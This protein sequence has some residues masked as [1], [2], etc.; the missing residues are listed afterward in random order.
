MN[1][2]SFNAAQ[3]IVE[4]TVKEICKDLRIADNVI[5]EN[6]GDYAQVAR[7][8]EKKYLSKKD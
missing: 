1:T 6:P 5:N 8:I 3:L 4:D 2:T 7:W